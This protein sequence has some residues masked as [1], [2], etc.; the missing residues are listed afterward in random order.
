MKNGQLRSSCSLEI[1]IEGVGATMATKLSLFSSLSG[2]SITCFFPFFLISHGAL[3]YYKLREL[4]MVS[5]VNLIFKL[6]KYK[7]IHFY[8]SE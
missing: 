4:M 7:I 3:V 6:K 5:V 1:P 8:Q 2:G